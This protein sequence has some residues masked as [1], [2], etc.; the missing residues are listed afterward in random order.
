M[1]VLQQKAMQRSHIAG[2]SEGYYKIRSFLQQIV[3]EMCA[4]AHRQTDTDSPAGNGSRR[5]VL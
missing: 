2:Q 5:E 4:T 1:C 3:F